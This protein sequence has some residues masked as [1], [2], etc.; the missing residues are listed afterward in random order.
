MSYQNSPCKVLLVLDNKTDIDLIERAIQKA[1]PKIHVDLARDGK[2][3]LS[4]MKAWEAGSPTPILILLDLKLPDMDGLQVLRALKTHSR[5]K[6]VPVVILS[7]SGEQSNLDQAYRMGVNSYITKAV[8]Y[9]EFAKAV[10]LI[11]HYWCELNVHP[12]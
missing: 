10:A 3:A 1:D 2:Q 6:I 11:R 7:A 4:C 9:D 12:E 8:D 5:Y